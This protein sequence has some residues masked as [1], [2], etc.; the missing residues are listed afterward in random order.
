[1]ILFVGN[2]DPEAYI[3]WELAVEKKFNSHLVP[4]KH[5]VRLATSEFTGFVLFWWSDLCATLRLI[6]MYLRIRML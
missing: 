2:A 1:M 6:M 5:R 4:T 3:D